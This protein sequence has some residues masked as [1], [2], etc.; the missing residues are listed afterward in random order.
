MDHELNAK[1]I[2]EYR[3]GLH[4]VAAQTPKMPDPLI[5]VTEYFELLTCISVVCVRTLPR[6]FRFVLASVKVLMQY[7]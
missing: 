5:Y 3:F 2:S 7:T 6:T 4:Y 1:A